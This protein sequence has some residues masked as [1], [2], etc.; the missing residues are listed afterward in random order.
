MVATRSR[1]WCFVC[2][3]G[4]IPI[5]HNLREVPVV[6]GGQGKCCKCMSAWCSGAVECPKAKPP[7]RTRTRHATQLHIH[8]PCTGCAVLQGL[9]VRLLLWPLG[10]LQM[11]ER[12]TAVLQFAFGP[13]KTN[14]DIRQQQYLT[15]TR[16]KKS[17]PQ[18]NSSIRE[19]GSDT[20]GKI[21]IPKKSTTNITLQYSSK[22]LGEWLGRARIAFANRAPI[23]W[24]K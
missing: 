3:R 12:P 16:R 6:P 2:T 7:Q 1:S 9:D 4:V 15:K 5:A 21:R 23:L 11:L 17:E 20:L 22:L 14:L 10:R 8:Q 18:A 24:G 13:G 19:Q